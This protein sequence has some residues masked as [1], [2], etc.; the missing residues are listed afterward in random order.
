MKLHTTTCQGD[1]NSLYEKMSDSSTILPLEN[2][3]QQLDL[4]YIS[5]LQ[6]FIGDIA[7]LPAGKANINPERH[8]HQPCT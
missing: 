7:D 3:F 6:S 8:S 2:E 1:I 5:N 4:C